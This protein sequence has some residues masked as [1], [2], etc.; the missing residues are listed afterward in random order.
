MVMENPLI[1]V[2]MIEVNA[3]Y[4][5]AMRYNVS[6]DLQT[7]INESAGVILSAVPELTMLQK[8]ASAVEK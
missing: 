8:L 6:S 1:Q 5:L 7:N 4:E 2:E 3:F